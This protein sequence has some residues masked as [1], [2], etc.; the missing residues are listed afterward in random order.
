MS[1]SGGG[2]FDERPMTRT[3]VG[4]L[5]FFGWISDD[6]PRSAPGEM[7]ISS[8]RD[9]LNL[10]ATLLAGHQLPASSLLSYFFSTASAALLLHS[11]NVAKSRRLH[12]SRCE[13]LLKD[14][15]KSY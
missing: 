8:I 1:S 6:R 15:S 10:I 11:S 2:L 12:L 13:T 9:V 3:G 5:S 14:Q 4:A 7:T